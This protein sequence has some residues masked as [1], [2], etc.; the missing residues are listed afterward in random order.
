MG[1]VSCFAL[2]GIEMWFNSLDHEPQH[3]HAK[4]SGEWEIRVFF[5]ATTQKDLAYNV[6]FGAKRIRTPDLNEMRNQVL[7][8][9]TRLLAEWHEK[10]CH[11]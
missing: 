4:K 10:V 6:V 1:R 2:D 7:T 3:F 9:R 5:L 11:D 8:H